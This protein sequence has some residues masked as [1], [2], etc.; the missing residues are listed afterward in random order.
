MNSSPAQGT[1]ANLNTWTWFVAEYR[2]WVI[3]IVTILGLVA[4][5]L[6]AS[7]KHRPPPFPSVVIRS[8]AMALAFSSALA[9]VCSLMHF[10]DLRWLPPGQRAHA[11]LSQPGGMFSFAKPIVGAVNSVTGIPVEFRAIQA[12][13]HVAI[14]CA[15]IALAA[16][17]VV[18]LTSRRARRAEVRQIVR[19]EIRRSAAGLGSRRAT[20]YAHE[21]GQRPAGLPRER[22]GRAI[23][24]YA[25]VV[26]AP[27]AT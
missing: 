3:V 19:E 14:I 8:G 2:V 4:P 26:G 15:L 5:F 23:G 20:D 18:A 9:T 13:V 6:G 10:S 21:R 17:L 27:A 11:H 16:G 24:S 12:S 22:G 1:L 7:R 25:N